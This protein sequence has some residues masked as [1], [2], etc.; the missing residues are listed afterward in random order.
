MIRWG[1]IGPGKIAGKFAKEVNIEGESRLVSVYGR[2][3]ERAEKF[4]K[5]NKAEKY[6]TDI[7]EFLNDEKIDAVYIATPHNNHIEFAVKS[8]KAGK[9]VLCE[10][11]FSYNYKTSREVFELAE[12]NDVFIMEALKSLFMPALNKAKEWI[13]EGKIGRVKLI[14][15]SFGSKNNE[16]ESP[17]LYELKSAGGALLDVGIYTIMLSNYMMNSAPEVISATA[18][19]TSKNVDETDSISLKYSNG[20]IASLTCSIACNSG[21]D[22]VIYG[23]NGKIVIPSFSKAKEVYLCCDDGE[24]KYTDTYEGYGMMYEIHEVNECIMNKKLQSETASHK[25][26]LDIAEVMDEVRKQIE[27]VYPFE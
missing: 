9:H 16:E 18:E 8:I 4:A 23:E 13:D 1:I 22:A 11:P 6:Y 5:E 19:M 14:T 2:N 7:D 20:A 25:M 17:R 27:M 3:E 15:A 26:T 24:E 12:K 21:K 10:K